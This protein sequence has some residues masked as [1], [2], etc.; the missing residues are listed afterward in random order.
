MKKILVLFAAISLS[1]CSFIMPVPHD[2]ALFDR[3]VT[4][5]IEVNK[6]SCDDRNW[7]KA[8]ADVNHLKVYAELRGDPQAE[9]IK[10][11]EAALTKAQAS[12]SVAFCQSALKLQQTR[13]KVVE[14]A[15]KGR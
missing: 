4:V 14:G 6:L 5:H 11:M 3:L 10:N 8:I 15:W 9:N 13:I 2:G 1:A 12:K 7:D